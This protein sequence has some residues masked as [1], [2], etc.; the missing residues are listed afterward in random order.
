VLVQV[1]R[2]QDAVVDVV[3]HP[4]ALDPRVVAAAEH[5]AVAEGAPLQPHPGR[6]PVAVAPDVVADDVDLAERRQ[7]LG[8]EGVG[9]DPGPV[10]PPGRADDL[11]IAAGVGAGVAEGVALGHHLVDHGVAGMALADVEAGVGR[12]RGI[13][14]LEQAVGR[15]EGVDAVVLL[16]IRFLLMRSWVDL[17]AFV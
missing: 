16:P 14:V 7:Q 6:V 5:D 12:P 10:V 1:G 2:D 11:Q 3:D 9:D 15:V 17:D 13:G 8:V 4:V